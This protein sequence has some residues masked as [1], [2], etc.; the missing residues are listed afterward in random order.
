[1]E[2]KDNLEE[3]CL[4]EHLGSHLV[5]LL[6][7][8]LEEV[9]QGNHLATMDNLKVDIR[10]VVGILLEVGNLEQLD[11]EDKLVVHPEL[12]LL[13]DRLVVPSNI[14]VVLDLV[15]LGIHRYE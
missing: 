13:E 12:S 2:L 9:L 3:A 14:P 10:P 11:L 6:V 15:V 8:H 4:V 5:E 7:G 1:V